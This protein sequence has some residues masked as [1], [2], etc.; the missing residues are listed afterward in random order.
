[1]RK[2]LHLQ[3]VSKPVSISQILGSMRKLP[4]LQ[5]GPK[6]DSMSIGSAHTEAAAREAQAEDGQEPD[7]KMAGGTGGFTQAGAG[8]GAPQR[9]MGTSWP[10]AKSLVVPRMLPSMQ[11]L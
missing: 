10:R 11:P 3:E 9:S 1:M 2:L 7:H 5:E 6:P 4:H 8:G